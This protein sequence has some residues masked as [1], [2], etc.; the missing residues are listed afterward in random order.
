MW[1]V[2]SEHGAVPS[3]V[4]VTLEVRPLCRAA[5]TRTRLGRCRWKDLAGGW[6]RGLLSG[7]MGTA[8]ALWG[9]LGSAGGPWDTRGTS[10]PVG[11]RRQSKRLLSWKPRKA[12]GFFSFVILFSPSGCAGIVQTFRWFMAELQLKLRFSNSKPMALSKW[13]LVN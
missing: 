4:L 9:P 6:S 1:R 5:D 2:V 12:V 7:R 8:M 13:S 10:E 11:S 3:L